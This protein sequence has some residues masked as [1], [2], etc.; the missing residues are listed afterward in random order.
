MQ[1]NEK[2]YIQVVVSVQSEE[3]ALVILIDPWDNCPSQVA[4]DDG[5][6]CI[7]CKHW[8]RDVK[9]VDWLEFSSCLFD[10]QD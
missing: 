9:G 3:S 8:G 7:D 2:R 4:K 1:L 10:G 5:R 6:N